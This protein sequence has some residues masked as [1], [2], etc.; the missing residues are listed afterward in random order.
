MT[1][2]TTTKNLTLMGGVSNYWRDNFLATYATTFKIVSAIYRGHL[3]ISLVNASNVYVDTL[4]CDLNRNVWWRNTNWPMRSAAQVHNVPEECYV[5]MGARVAQ[6]STCWSPTAANKNDADGTAVTWTIESAMH[7]GFMRLH[8]RW[9]VSQAIQ[10]WRA[11]YLDYDMRDAAS[12]NPSI[13]VSVLN[14]SPESTTYT[15]ATAGTAQPPD[16]LK[17][18]AWSRIRMLINHPSNGLAYKLQS[19]NA[20]ADTRIYGVESEYAGREGSRTR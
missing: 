15:D 10:T 14:D 5:G 12:D 13:R 17:T 8:R 11:L 4:V 7:R 1:D 18:S 9:I 3:I 6:V 16:P 20:S 19:T 2:G